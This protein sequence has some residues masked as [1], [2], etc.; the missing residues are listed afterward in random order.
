M[1]HDWIDEHQVAERY[2]LGQLAAAEAAEFEEHSLGCPECLDRLEAAEGLAAGLKRAAAQEAAL[3]GVVLQAGLFARLARLSRSRQASILAMALLLVVILP[4]GL[5]LR[6]VGEL[7]RELD[8]ARQR[9]AA[10][11]TPAPSAVVSARPPAAD[12]EA[13]LRAARAAAAEYGRAQAERRAKSLAAELAEARQPL[14]NPLLLT[15]GAERS[16]PGG[17]EPS[18]R[19]DL[20]S[21][22]PWV[23][24]SL[25]LDAP[26]RHSYDLALR[27]PDGRVRWRG[28]GFVPDGKG[29]LSVAFPRSL[30]AP[31][32][33]TV[34]VL[35]P[36]PVA[37]FTFRVSAG[38]AGGKG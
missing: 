18:T 21:A 12:P 36:A 28:K 9:P 4:G 10:A 20:A 15:L 23:V 3:W 37:R 8:R 26:A 13:P 32:D 35:G 5:L 22:P 17:A 29:D 14:V 34:E 33:S 6:R 31:G 19:I 38:T 25:E 24:L 27:G 1:E 11:A 16:A 2:L 30:L 7:G